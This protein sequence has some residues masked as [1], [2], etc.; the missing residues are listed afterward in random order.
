MQMFP[1]MYGGPT[2]EQQ[3]EQ[4]ASQPPMPPDGMQGGPMPPMD[5]QGGPMQQPMDSQGMPP[6]MMASEQ[7]TQDGAL[8]INPMV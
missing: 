8:P 7:M 1:L 6:E 2:L 3:A 4:M 5:P